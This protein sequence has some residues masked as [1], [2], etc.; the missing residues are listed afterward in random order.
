MT[1]E[2][3]EYK[4]TA[5]NTNTMHAKIS[6]R[7]VIAR[8][9]FVETRPEYELLVNGINI[10]FYMYIIRYKY[11]M[12]SFDTGVL[13][14]TYKV[15]DIFYYKNGLIQIIQIIH[16]DEKAYD[17]TTN[18]IQQFYTIK[19][20][21]NDNVPPTRMSHDALCE[22]YIRLNETRSKKP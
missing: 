12:S 2:R 20:T 11:T 1:N 3:V 16:V 10:P 17:Y 9:F 4:K 14:N 7:S 21:Q 5:S 8:M 13:T 22:Y 6:N 19:Y 18:T 15:G